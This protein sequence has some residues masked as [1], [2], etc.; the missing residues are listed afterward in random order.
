MS[1]RESKIIHDEPELHHY[2]VLS[3][4][5]VDLLMHASGERD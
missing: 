2:R 3:H 4:K 5:I 1:E